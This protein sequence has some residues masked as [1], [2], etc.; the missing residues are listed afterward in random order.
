MAVNG[1]EKR[2]AKAREL[3]EREAAVRPSDGGHGTPRDNQSDER[4][5]QGVAGSIAQL[6]SPI[7]VLVH[8]LLG[9]QRVDKS[10]E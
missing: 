5:T 4:P 9:A 3:T 10:P 8:W 1:D 2:V 6:P 7:G